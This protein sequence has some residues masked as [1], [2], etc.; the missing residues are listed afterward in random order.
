M[1]ASVGNDGSLHPA[2]PKGF[3]VL[4]FDVMFDEHHRPHLLEVNANTSLSVMQPTAE[5]TEDGRK[6]KVC[7][8]DHVVKEE[9]VSQ[10]LLC[11]NPFPHHIALRK[12]AAWLETLEEG[13]RHCLSGALPGD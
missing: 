7:E 4:G 9:L 8:L 11:V 2:G 6:T 3:H 1:G 5:L 10:A 12:R 13:R